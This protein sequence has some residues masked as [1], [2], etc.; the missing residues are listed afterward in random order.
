MDSAT[1]IEKLRPRCH[2]AMSW[3]VMMLEATKRRLQMTGK[4]NIFAAAPSLMKDWQR[5]IL[6]LLRS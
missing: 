4:L 5:A 3:L 6:P 2:I 1:E